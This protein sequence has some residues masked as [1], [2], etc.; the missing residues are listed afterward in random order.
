MAK[1]IIVLDVILTGKKI[2]DV[3]HES[4]FTVK[5]IQGMLDLSCPQPIYRWMHGNTLPSVDNL[6]RLS[7][8]LKM[9]MEDMLVERRTEGGKI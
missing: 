1:N 4:G 3:I 2:H 7:R 8:I 5:E 6:Y 9:H